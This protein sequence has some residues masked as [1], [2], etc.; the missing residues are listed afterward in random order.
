MCLWLKLGENYFNQLTENIL[1]G[2]AAACGPM[3]DMANN[4]TLIHREVM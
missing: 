3:R 2:R 4:K 1:P